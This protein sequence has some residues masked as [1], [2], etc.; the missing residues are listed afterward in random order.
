MKQQQQVQK[1]TL[2]KPLKVHDLNTVAKK[3][4]SLV[5]LALTHGIQSSE[6]SSDICPYQQPC[7]QWSSQPGAG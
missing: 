1:A 5:T 7:L 6:V 3:G 4:K 2:V